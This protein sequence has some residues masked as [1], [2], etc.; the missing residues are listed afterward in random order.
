MWVNGVNGEYALFSRGG[1]ITNGP[2][3][4][5]AFGAGGTAY[6]FNYGYGANGLPATPNRT[7]AGG[8]AGCS[9]GGY[10]LNGDTSG[11]QMGYASMVARLER[12]DT[13]TRLSYDLTP[14]I[15]LYSTIMYS[16]V[17]TW[18]KPTQDFYKAANLNIGCDNPYLPTAIATACFQNNGQTA[19]YN[20]QFG[21]P[22]A[23]TGSAYT[24]APYI[25]NGAGG[26][27]VSNGF[28]NG[29]TAGAMQYGTQNAQMTSVE[30][31]N[32]RTMRR[33]V[34]GS[35]GVFNALGTD[36]A[37]KGYVEI[38]QSDYH[39]VLENQLI[40]P[41]YDAAIDAVQV[42]SANSASFPGVPVGSVICR[43]AAARS[44][45]CAPMNIIGP[46]GASAAALSFVEGLNG[47]GSSSGELGREP[48]QI[49]DQRQDVVDFNISGEPLST[50]AGKIAM[51][52]GFQYR[53]EAFNAVTDC[54]SQGNCAN[55]VFG[56][57]QYG[58]GGDPLLNA[59]SG[60]G[61]NGNPL[62]PAAPNWYAGNF[63]PAHGVF[64]EWEIFEETNVP[65]L[66]DSA[67]GKIDANVAGRYTHYTTSGDVETWKVGATWDT[68]V[69]GLRLRALQSRD[70]RAPNLAELFAGAR[71]NN[72]SV[73]DDFVNLQ[74][75]GIANASITPLP[76]PI[77]ANANL[78]PEKG[79]TTEL[80]LVWSP[81]Y[82]PGL[83]LSATYY[84]VGVKGEITQLSQ[85]QEMDLCFQGNALQCS[86]IS[87]NGTPWAS[88][89][90]I[91]TAATQTTPT[92][93]ITPNVNI[94]S[95]TT[96][97][98]DYEASYRFSP[99]DV[100]DWGLGGDIT[101]RMLTTN[102]TSFITN[103][104]FVG[105]VPVESAG[106]N[107]G[108][109]PHWKVFFTQAYDT[110]KWGFFVNERWFSQGVINRNWVTCSTACPAPLNANYPT[111]SSNYMPG[112]LYFDIGGNY[113]L[114]D[115]S[116]I[117]Y[118]V[119]NVTN[120]NPGNANPFGV[121]SQSYVTNPYLYDM[122]GRY[123]HIGF[124]INE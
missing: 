69:D 88:N 9:P 16:E 118:K 32:N 64:H 50:W 53:E 1:M 43:S 81:S 121:A 119:D 93:Q 105:A 60:I 79:Q 120:Q 117:Y 97:G 6:Q 46:N 112:E 109:T 58:P 65:L 23:S 11:D 14:N 82:V 89:G 4:G 59:S 25:A 29:F 115:H 10:C 74:K 78:K 22:I 12:G 7:A 102:V 34:V 55:Q 27:P 52:T 70:V 84:R 51:A 62:P 110:D 75:G 61:P 54:A 44:V 86:F 3:Q 36:W 66:N 35:D 107:G 71:V 67:W 73:T 17:V 85:Q 45:G 19:A 38:G 13:F 108:F 95:V 18:D 106:S 37:F 124:R 56:G 104:G 42:S 57:V 111:V 99:D 2:L 30:N 63:Q 5:T 49:V 98:V 21:F 15:E 72:G 33:Y 92:S 8:I 96:E 76:N 122:I 39:N 103:P 91:N 116:Q 83:N 28:V 113:N 94:A 114:T 47:D 123:Y 40:T 90:V 80:G 100:V 20:S 31:Y 101:F 87:S 26:A 48:W 68:P 41:Y 77:T 24:A